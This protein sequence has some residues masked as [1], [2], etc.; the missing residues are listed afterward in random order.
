MRDLAPK[1]KHGGMQSRSSVAT[2][3]RNSIVGTIYRSFRPLDMNFI[4]TNHISSS[5]SSKI[6]DPMCDRSMKTDISND[7]L[8]VMLNHM[9]ESMV[10][11][12]VFLGYNSSK[13]FIASE[14]PGFK[15]NH[16]SPL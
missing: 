8:F 9:V 10:D 6:M 13:I 1:R 15:G 5:F 7:A 3:T 16:T 2:I 14:F 4:P 11:R 12:I